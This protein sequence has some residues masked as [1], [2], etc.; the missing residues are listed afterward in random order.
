LVEDALAIVAKGFFPNEE[1]PAA[2]EVAM[3]DIN[4]KMITA[5]RMVGK[6]ISR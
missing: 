6:R 4:A 5:R 2:E 1:L 3:M